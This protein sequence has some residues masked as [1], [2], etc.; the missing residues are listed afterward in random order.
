MRDPQ[1]ETRFPKLSNGGYDI[2]SPKDQK[3]NCVAFAIGNPT[4]NW[5]WMPYK[6]GGYY[7]PPDIE[8]DETLRAWTRVFEIHGYR[9]CETGDFEPGIE[10][11]ALYTDSDGVPSHVAKQDIL[12]GK[13]ISKL[14]KGYD[15][16]HDS[17]DVL[18]GFDEHEY[19]VAVRFMSR[20][21]KPSLYDLS[22][23]K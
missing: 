17:Y 2:K 8:G 5:N 6:T 14:G 1:L 12:T 13:W 7:W 22:P 18:E 3:Y 9:Q 11:I 4:R 20:L 10:K 23:N 16:E 21:R 19:G 15:I